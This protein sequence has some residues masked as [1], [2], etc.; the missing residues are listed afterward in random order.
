[1]KTAASAVSWVINLVIFLG[2]YGVGMW[3]F[4]S[5]AL[6]N[7]GMLATLLLFGAGAVCVSLIKV[8]D[9]KLKTK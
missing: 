1:M 8:V 2:C 4:K 3:G 5:A 9:D 7:N 6:Q